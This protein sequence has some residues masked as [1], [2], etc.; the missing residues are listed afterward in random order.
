MNIILFGPPG[1]GKG[2]QANNLV[3][4]FNLFK[5]SSGDLLRDE[6][7]KKNLLG[8]KIKSIINQGLFVPDD[9][10]NALV[11]NILSNKSYFNRMIFDGSPRNIKQVKN[12][13]LLLKKNNQKISCVLN[14]KVDK[15]IIV[16]RILGRQICA[17]CGLTFNQFFSPAT[18][19]NHQC[20]SKF[21]QKRSD[22][23]EETATSRLKTYEKETLPIFNHY[24]DLNLLYEID[25]MGDISKIYKEIRHIISSLET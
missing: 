12:L 5:V 2:T 11:E 24:Q 18:K 4:E 16:K 9:I 14:L 8:D 25:G 21:L 3:K 19:D 17:K 10:I 23:N 6:I 20:D 13:H 22:D 1:A 7:K 15:K